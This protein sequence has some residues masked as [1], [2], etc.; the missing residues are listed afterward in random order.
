MLIPA[1]QR[2]E[3]AEPRATRA[4]PLPDAG[5]PFVVTVAALTTGARY[6]R[7]R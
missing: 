5:V 2:S 6:A 7:R 3:T 1:R 4:L